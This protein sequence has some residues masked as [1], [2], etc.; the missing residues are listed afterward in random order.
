MF[1]RQN[2]LSS[3]RIF[4]QIGRRGIKRSGEYIFVRALSA[5]GNSVRF[6]VVMSTKAAKLATVRNRHKR[7]VRDE[8]RPLI[9][10]ISGSWNIIVTIRQAATSPDGEQKIREEVRKL[11]ASPFSG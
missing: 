3:R 4:G 7:I 1:S 6:A 10:K 9:S 8:L 5:N 2:R 11:F